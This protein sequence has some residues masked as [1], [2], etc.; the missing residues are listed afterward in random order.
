MNQQ[1]I[2]FKRNI[3]SVKTGNL[4]SNKDLPLPLSFK[5]FPVRRKHRSLPLRK[6]VRIFF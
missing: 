2:I 3:I 6:T 5:D 1:G 4:A